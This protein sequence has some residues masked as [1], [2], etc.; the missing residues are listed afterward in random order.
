VSI[1]L[2]SPAVLQLGWLL[3]AFSTEPD[4]ATVEDVAARLGTRLAAQWTPEAFLTTRK[5]MGE[6][7]G[8]VTVEQLDATNERAWV[9]VRAQDGSTWQITCAVDP[10]DPDKLDTVVV[11][12]HPWPGLTPRLPDVFDD[13]EPPTQQP[14]DGPLRMIVFSGVPGTGKSSLADALGSAV[15][16][17]VFAIDWLLGALD[18]FGGRRLEE[19]GMAGYELL[20]TLA[21]RQLMLGQS[22][23]LDSPIE[24]IPTRQRWTSLAERFGAEMVV[25]DCICSDPDLHK[26]R[27]E[28]RQRGIPGWHEGGNWENVAKRVAEYPKWAQDVLTVDAVNSLEDNL[29]LVRDHVT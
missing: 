20:T 11:A 6:R 29:R 4:E 27:V 12:P 28:G 13:Y 14:P 10:G 24:E 2:E 9:V 3:S 5:A 21:L 18:P 7:V 16:V 26:T 19:L 25:I 8:A 23:I 15:G 17:P 1:P 22:V